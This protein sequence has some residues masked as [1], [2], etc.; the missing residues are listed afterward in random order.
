MEIDIFEHIFLICYHEFICIPVYFSQKHLL[1]HQPV[2]MQI[3]LMVSA[4]FV[5]VQ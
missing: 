2:N 4:V 1:R 5:G 3:A